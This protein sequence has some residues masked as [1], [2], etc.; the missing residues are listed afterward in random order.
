MNSPISRQSFLVLLGTAALVVACSRAPAPPPAM[1]APEVGVVTLQSVDV[2]WTRELVGRLAATRVADVRARVAGILQKR[3]Y[4]EGTDVHEGQLLFQIDPAPLKAALDAQLANLAAAEAIYQNAHR[5]AERARAIAAKGLLSKTELDNAEAT[6]RSAAAAVKQAAANVETARIN[7]GYAAVT[8]P[9][10]GRAGVQRVTEGALVGQ[11][12]ATL[13]TTIEQLDPIYVYFTEAVEEVDRLRRAAARG[14][15]ELAAQGKAQIELLQ[16]DGSSFGAVGTL[17]FSDT[18]VDPATGAVALRGIVPNPDHALLPGRYVKVRVTF[19]ERKQVFRV[20][21]AALLRDAAGAYVFAVGADRI[22]VQKRVQTDG[23][24]TDGW[25]VTDGLRDGDRIVVS[26]VQK[27]HPG[28][29]V[30]AIT[31]RPP[32]A[33]ATPPALSH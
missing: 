28:M 25:W 21:P 6:E 27:V 29:P 23:L 18:V 8:A 10:G 2:P 11:G 19:G 26:G 31:W 32:S 1:P 15:A 5:A 9:I 14:Q 3:M 22:V 4:T 24:D 17:D 30:Q 16:A 33:T 12:E 20:D 13:L 7:L